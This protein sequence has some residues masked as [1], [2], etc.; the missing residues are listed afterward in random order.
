MDTVYYIEE[1]K[2]RQI[3]FPSSRNATEDLD[4]SLTSTAARPRKK[5]ASAR[6]RAAVG[7]AHAVGHLTP[8]PGPVRPLKL[9]KKYGC[10]FEPL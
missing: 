2:N 3:L 7:D 5:T 10:W 4:D 8:H 9:W 1:V 6:H